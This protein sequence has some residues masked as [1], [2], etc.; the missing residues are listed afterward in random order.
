MP[1]LSQT[2]LS[3]VALKI[4]CCQFRR[5]RKISIRPIMQFVLADVEMDTATCSSNLGGEVS[6]HGRSPL[7]DEPVCSPNRATL[8]PK[9][10]N[11]EA[12]SE[13]RWP[14]TRKSTPS[15]DSGTSPIST[16][17][18]SPFWSPASSISSPRSSVSPWHLVRRPEGGRPGDRVESKLPG[19]V[20]VCCCVIVTTF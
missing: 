6:P 16:W 4:P 12:K 9:P 8:N 3:L 15:V 1:K 14:V 20:Y 19:W 17:S 7:D 10:K 5:P 2:R 13:P 11:D 18:T